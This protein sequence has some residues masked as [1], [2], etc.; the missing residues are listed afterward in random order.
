[1]SKYT[2][3]VL[4]KILNLMITNM[5]VVNKQ[6]T[7]SHNHIKANLSLRLSVSSSVFNV[8]LFLGE[9]QSGW[10]FIFNNIQEGAIGLFLPLHN[11]IIHMPFISLQV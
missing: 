9:A 6:S 10:P 7:F 5:R 2:F 4:F 3:A 11:I 8:E 1:M